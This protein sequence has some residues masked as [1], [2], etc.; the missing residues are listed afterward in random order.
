[1]VEIIVKPT[2]GSYSARAKGYKATASRSD[3]ERQAAEA[4]VRKLDL[5]PGQLEE[6]MAE[7]LPQGYKVFHFCPNG[8]SGE[9]P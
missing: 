7:G 1:M 5:G 6:R 9:T 3:G 2:L 4:L 8:E